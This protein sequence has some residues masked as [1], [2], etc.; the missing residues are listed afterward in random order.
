[1]NVVM[2]VSMS[3]NVRVNVNETG[4][5]SSAEKKKGNRTKTHAP[6]EIGYGIINKIGKKKEKQHR[7]TKRCR[8]LLVLHG[9]RIHG[10]ADKKNGPRNKK[11]D[12]DQIHG[13]S[14]STS[15]TPP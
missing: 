12:L 14:S 15:R 2:I 9:V 6:N 1:M 8:K 10:T 4:S 7:E 3:M 5:T 13:A 11:F